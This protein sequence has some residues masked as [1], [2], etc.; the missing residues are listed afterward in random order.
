MASSLE[1][2]G[3]NGGVSYCSREIRCSGSLRVRQVIRRRI[4]AAAF[5]FAVTRVAVAGCPQPARKAV[6]W[7]HLPGT[8]DKR[9][10]VEVGRAGFGEIRQSTLPEAL[11]LLATT[12]SVELDRPA[13]ERF[14]FAP[15]HGTQGR[16]FLIRAIRFVGGGALVVRRSGSAVF[17]VGVAMGDRDPCDVEQTAVIVVCE[18]VPSPVYVSYG[19]VI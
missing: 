13:A 17:V 11:S 5:L 14:G 3:V 15:S 18:S 2:W 6:S 19:V 4:C 12:A 7:Q 16:L 1:P 10:W 9:V 8:K